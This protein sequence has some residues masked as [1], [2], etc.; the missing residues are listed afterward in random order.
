VA[1]LHELSEI[2][3]DAGVLAADGELALFAQLASKGLPLALDGP[4]ADECG[5]G[6]VVRARA[7]PELPLR[8]RDANLP[9]GRGLIGQALVGPPGWLGGFAAGDLLAVRLVGGALEV[10]AAS[11]PM[12]ADTARAAAVAAACARRRGRGRAAV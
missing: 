4:G 11:Q 12:A 7:L 6:G 9:A 1:V 3:A 5:S 8:L 10:T 2:E